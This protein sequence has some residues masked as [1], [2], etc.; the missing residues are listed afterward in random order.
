M[1]NESKKNN[2]RI[3]VWSVI[4]ALALIVAGVVYN[5]NPAKGRVVA[6]LTVVGTCVLLALLPRRSD[7]CIS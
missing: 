3:I 7:N 5:G 4:W 6:V 1:T 2:T